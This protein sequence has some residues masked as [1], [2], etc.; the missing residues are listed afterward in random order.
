[1][2]IEQL[3]INGFGRIQERDMALGDGVT[4]L[5]GRNEAGKSTT[6]QFIRAMLYG[7]PSR[8]Y[9]SE[10]YEPL[11]GGSHGGTLQARDREGG[12]WKISRFAGGEGQGRGDKLSIT[13]S[14]PNGTLQEAGQPELERELLGGISRS[15]FRQLFA[16][17]LDE[18]QELSAL[19]SDEMSSY[20]FHAGMGGG[21]EVMRAERR[22]L[23]E[24]EKLYKPRGR[25]QETAKILQTIEKLERERAESRSYLPRYNEN[26]AALEETEEELR[27]LEAIRES[28]VT[29]LSKLRK[30]VEIRELWLKWSAAKLELASLPVVVSFP[31]NGAVRLQEMETEL[32]SAE[33]AVARIRRQQEEL[34]AELEQLPVDERLLA[35][36]AALERLEARRSAYEDRCSER[37]RLEGELDALRDH[38]QRVLRSVDHA[39]RREELQ[40]LVLSAGE[41]ETA[42]R[43]AA[44]FSSYDRRM[45]SQGAARQ[46][47]RSRLAAASASLQ[48][49]ERALA[50]ELDAGAKTFAALR[51]SS[52]AEVLQLWDELQQAA[53]RWREAL[54]QS[55]QRG[56]GR[57]EAMGSPMAPLYR[58]LLLPG[59][60][61]AALL[62]AALWLTGAPPVSAWLTL[63]VLIAAELALWAG[64]RRS[65]RPQ[66]SP[67]GHGGDPVSAAA[68]M[69]R[70]RGLLLSGA[71]PESAEGRPLR[72]S[73]GP[74]SPDA[75]GLEAGMKELRRL[76][77]AWAAWRQRVERAEEAREACRTELETL[78]GQEQ[79]LASEMQQ[80]E[81]AFTATASQYEAWLRSRSLPEGLSPEGLP[82]IFRVVEQGHELLRQENKL[83]LRLQQLEGDCTLFEEEGFALM[84]EAGDSAAEVAASSPFFDRA[85]GGERRREA[86]VRKLP[87]WLETR[88][89]AWDELRS[90]LLRRD[91]LISRLRSAESEGTELQLQLE[92]LHKRYAQLLLEGGTDNPEDFLRRSAAVH[93][94]GEL[95]SSLREWELAMFSGW[96][97][98][99]G[100]ELLSLLD[101]RDVTSLEEEHVNAERQLQQEEEARSVLLERRGKLLQE[102]SDLEVRCR[103]DSAAQ[104]L[105]EQRAALQQIAEQYAVT[106]I[107]AALIGRTRRIYEQDKQPQVMRLASEYFNKLTEGEYLRVVMTLGH[108]ELKAEHRSRGLLDSGLLSRGT[109]EQLYLALRLALAQTMSRQA[110]LPLL[111][112]DL[113][114]NFDD[115]RL[116]A[117]LSLLGALSKTRQIVMMTCHR[118]VA[119]AASS[120]IPTATVISV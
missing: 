28:T 10:R 66:M 31:E 7:I 102:R 58:R 55:P 119:E 90:V 118:H 5:Y 95:E 49:A 71:E 68:E 43:F 34:T 4:V 36:G 50:R 93:Q 105:E 107:T 104:Q 117:A 46:A 24:A 81:T 70:L 94:R 13:V 8:S 92:E 101:S 85:E 114:V 23:Q 37:Q 80:E 62:P 64:L 17:T 59:A 76:M 120:S 56:A 47:L 67:P 73:A 18:L 65:G 6:L 21:G 84:A 38:L 3:H 19:Q 48:A 98:E 89:K 9:P 74:A 60:A 14:R 25:V 113:F 40:A 87:G 112:D 109:A 110:N 35:Q 16:V 99:G 78:S 2:K 30:T 63:G 111:L 91:A 69:V 20:L 52:S 41:R 100:D 86:W 15:M 79:A 27:K 83:H 97:R 53:E 57:R 82:E 77:E 116:H 103:Q 11:L 12:V 96:S 33:A 1:M 26:T 44:D 108:K 88:K 115:Q 72:R 75:S 29:R 51:P 32:R 61:L 42:R 54:L 45:E 106:A 39:W 22:L